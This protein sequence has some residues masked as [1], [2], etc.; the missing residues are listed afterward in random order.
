MA[1]R[2]AGAIVLTII[3]VTS[4]VAVETVRIGTSDGAAQLLVDGKPVRARMFWGAPG[5]GQLS[6]GPEAEKVMFEF[7]ATEDEPKRATM[8]LRFGSTPGDVYL[9]AP[10]TTGPPRP[11]TTR[12]VACSTV[13][14]ST[15]FAR[16]FPI[17]I[18]A[19][20]RAP[21]R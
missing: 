10:Y 2:L 11:A 1:I 18:V 5:R 20:V 16:R 17:S 9:G 8:H 6:I 15:F 19:W 14:T 7:S 12:C 3:S 4:A 13:R 21:R